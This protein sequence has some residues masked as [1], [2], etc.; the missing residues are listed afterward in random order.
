MADYNACFAK[1]PANTKDLHRPLWAGDDLDEV[2]AWKE[3]RTLS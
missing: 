2:F 1:A 3:E